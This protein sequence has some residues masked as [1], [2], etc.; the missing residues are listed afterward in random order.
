MDSSETQRP[1]LGTAAF[2]AFS[3]S[4]A[5]LARSRPASDLDVPLAAPLKGEL[6]PVDGTGTNSFSS[7]NVLGGN[8]T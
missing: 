7:F 2:L 4:K 8:P 5:C 3:C 6:I 1:K